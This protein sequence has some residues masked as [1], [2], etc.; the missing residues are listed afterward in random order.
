M[1]GHYPKIKKGVVMSCERYCLIRSVVKEDP[2]IS[3][4][5][6]RNCLQTDLIADAIA[7]RI[8]AILDDSEESVPSSELPLASESV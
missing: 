2:W 4:D 8:V 6:C 3:L 1:V 7:E 5:L